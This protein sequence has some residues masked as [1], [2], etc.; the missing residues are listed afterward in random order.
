MKER[1]VNLKS[2]SAAAAVVA[3]SA[4]PMLA[5]AT[6]AVASPNGQITTSVSATVSKD[7]K[8]NQA[9]P[10]TLAFGTIN[11]IRNAQAL[12]PATSFTVTC[13]N[14]TAWHLAA[15]T[16]GQNPLDLTQSGYA[17]AFNENPNVTYKATT[18]ILGATATSSSASQ[19]VNLT[20]TFLTADP[21]I[22][23]YTGS[24]V[25]SVMI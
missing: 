12:T 4:A 24:F 11:L 6:G 16:N 23:T 1:S 19:T 8:I 22:G 25:I 20:G 10:L 9:G 3:L 14:G 15:D 7:C 13:N 21:P 17:A 18:D 2:I 5:G